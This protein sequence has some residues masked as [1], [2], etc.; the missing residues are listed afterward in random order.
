M[1]RTPMMGADETMVKVRC[2]ANLMGFVA[3]AESGE[4]LGIGMLVERDDDGFAN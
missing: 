3:D 1:S 2:K 4:L